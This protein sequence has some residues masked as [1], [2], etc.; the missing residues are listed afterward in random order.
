MFTLEGNYCTGLRINTLMSRYDLLSQKRLLKEDYAV[1]DTSSAF[2]KKRKI[3][4]YSSEVFRDVGRALMISI[5]DLN[6]INPITRIL[7]KKPKEQ[8]VTFD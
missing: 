8:V 2:Y 3:P 4:I 7:K 6:G 1:C 5:L